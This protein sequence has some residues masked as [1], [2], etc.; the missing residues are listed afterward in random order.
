MDNSGQSNTQ[1]ITPTPMGAQAPEMPLPMPP[2]STPEVEPVAST[3][4]ATPAPAAEPVMP[5]MPE[6]PAIQP[7]TPPASGVN[8]GTQPSAQA[9]DDSISPLLAAATNASNKEMRIETLLEECVKRNASDLHIQVGLP[10]ILRIDGAL[11]PMA[12]MSVLKEDVVQK[13]VFATLDSEQ[14][15]TLSKD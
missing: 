5:A 8:G 11:V 9:K 12:G 1:P 4:V 6:I 10:P 7:A 3:P 15:E 14:R 13:L 2:I